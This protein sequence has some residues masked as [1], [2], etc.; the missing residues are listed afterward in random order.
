MTDRQNRMPKTL[1]K[2][3]MRRFGGCQVCGGGVIGG[4][5]HSPTL[6]VHHIIARAAG[7]ADTAD[8]AMLVC[9]PCHV[10]I[11]KGENHEN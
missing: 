3:L 6:E 1:K 2:R 5:R 9:R 4:S 8:N 11:H 10:E 7:G